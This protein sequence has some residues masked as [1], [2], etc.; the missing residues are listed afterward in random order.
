MQKQLCRQRIDE[1]YSGPRHACVPRKSRILAD[2]LIL[3]EHTPVYTNGR[4]N[5][6]ALSADETSRLQKLGCDYVETNRGGEITFHG[7]GQLVAYPNMYLKDHYL[8]TKC[9]VKGLEYTI[10]ETCARLGIDAD[11]VDGFPGVWVSQTEKVAALGTHMQKYVTSHG[12]ALNCT[13]EM[14]WFTEIVPCG[15]QGKS[16]TSLASVLAKQGRANVDA[17]VGAVLPMVIDSFKA[18][19]GCDVLP[20]EQV[21]PE[22]YSIIT[23][24]V[25]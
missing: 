11:I 2:T 14:R 22:T 8:G 12:F 25:Q 21:S 18:V 19:F 15:L 16:A 6:G 10:V 20:L 4:R 17:S 23:Q 13:T 5:Y 3:L 24:L 9:Y 7:P 1:I